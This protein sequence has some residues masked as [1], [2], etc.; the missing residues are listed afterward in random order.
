M[1]TE[2]ERLERL[3]GEDFGDAYTIRNQDGYFLR[4]DFWLKIGTEY[5][6]K[7][8][9]EVGCNAGNNLRWLGSASKADCYGIDINRSALRK[10]RITIPGLNLL[11]GKARDLPFK[12]GLF[13]LVFTCGVLI[14]QP[15]DSLRKVMSE[16]IRVSNRYV[17][18]M[19]YHRPVRTVIP[20]RDEKDA[21]FGDD[22]GGI[23][24]R[25]FGL[26]SIANGTLSKSEG[27]DNVTWMVL[28]K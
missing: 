10:G 20:Y 2:A 18:T 4:K 15:E 1:S 8:V 3:W 16:V 19:E 27:F 5:K 9:L 24:Q 13:D 11:Y 21:L 17:L 6:P 22:Y 26:R 25:E 14:H 23:Y 12:D 7:K 28:E